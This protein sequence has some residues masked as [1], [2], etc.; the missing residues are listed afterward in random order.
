MYILNPEINIDEYCSP[1]SGWVDMGSYYERNGPFEDEF[2]WINKNS[3]KVIS[4][5]YSAWL[6]ENCITGV[7]ILTGECVI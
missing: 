4:N 2:I 3:R 1:D 7:I 5:G 6:A